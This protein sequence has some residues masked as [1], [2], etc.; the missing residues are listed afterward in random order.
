MNASLFR[1]G[2]LSQAP[3]AV[4]ATPQLAAQEARR[5]NLPWGLKMPRKRGPISRQRKYEEMLADALRAGRV[6]E[7]A[8]LDDAQVPGWW[9]PSMGFCLSPPDEALAAAHECVAVDEAQGELEAEVEAKEADG[10]A[11]RPRKNKP[12]SSTS[13]AA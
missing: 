9:Q 12:R 13:Q 10:E 5:L 4:D 2:H 3:R 1:Y 11:K 7:V 8:L 6:A